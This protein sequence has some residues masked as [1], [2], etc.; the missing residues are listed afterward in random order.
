[1]INAGS[2]S[3]MEELKARVLKLRP[4]ATLQVNLEEPI[5]K[6]SIHDGS[7]CLSSF[8]PTENSA[9]FMALKR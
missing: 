5:L 1:M 3:G 9:W 8:M 2:T 4:N 7:F 6:Y